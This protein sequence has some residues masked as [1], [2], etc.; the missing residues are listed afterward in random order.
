MA[1]L[2]LLYKAFSR[3]LNWVIEPEVEIN[4][5]KHTKG[6]FPICYALIHQLFLQK[7]SGT[8]QCLDGIVFLFPAEC[9]R[10]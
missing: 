5:C 10:Y 8:L 2:H 7:K 1:I 3:N 9:A 6:Q 4:P